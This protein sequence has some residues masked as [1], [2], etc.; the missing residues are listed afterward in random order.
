MSFNLSVA[1]MK[2]CYSVKNFSWIFSAHPEKAKILP[3]NWVYIASF[4][5]LPY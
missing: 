2:N 5:I 3:L 4:H 1:R